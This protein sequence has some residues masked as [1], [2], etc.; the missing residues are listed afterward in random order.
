MTFCLRSQTSVQCNTWS[1]RSPPPD[2]VGRAPHEPST[3]AQGD[4][5]KMLLNV[6][7]SD[8]FT[9]EV[10]YCV[11]KSPHVV[12]LEFTP[13]GAHNDPGVLRKLLQDKIDAAHVSERTYDAIVL[14][15][16]ICGN[17]TIGLTGPGTPLVIPRAHD[18]ACWILFSSVCQAPFSEIF[19]TSSSAAKFFITHG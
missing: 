7:A 1:R 17:S 8:V 12:D 10:C 4:S 2:Y 15:L 3:F 11:A 6:I 18:S 9:R 5:W 13:R 14:C 19:L 16:G